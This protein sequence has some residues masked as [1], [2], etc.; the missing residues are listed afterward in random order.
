MLSATVAPCLRRGNRAKGGTTLLLTATMLL[1]V[2]ATTLAGLQFLLASRQVA[3]YQLEQE[4][5]FRTAETALL[6]AEAELM[7]ALSNGAS[8]V[9]SR[10][11][12][13]P[14]PGQCGAGAQ[15]GLC[16]PAPG[17]P[18]PWLNWLDSR[19]P[20]ETT[21]IAM[22]S[23]SGVILPALPP[24]AAG[25]GAM[26]RYVAELMHERPPGEWLGSGYTPGT[27][28]RLRF[29]ITA[30]G[31]GRDAAVRSLLQSEFQP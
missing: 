9:D 24:G 29:R 2:A 14:P 18:P 1:L 28:Q 17:M 21:G 15:R 10:L 22:G 3:T 8:G 16:R 13:W 12:A 7:T 25:A 31:L 19:R 4:I 30:L 20:D 23:F 6:D 27:G 26:P 5:A 11:A